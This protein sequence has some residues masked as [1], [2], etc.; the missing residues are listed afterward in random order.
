ML[1]FHVMYNILRIVA[2]NYLWLMLKKIYYILKNHPL[3]SVIM[4]KSSNFDA[5]RIFPFLQRSS[6]L[7]QSA[8]LIEL[9]SSETGAISGELKEKSVSS[10]GIRSRGED[11]WKG[12]ESNLRRAER[13]NPSNST[14]FLIPAHFRGYSEFIFPR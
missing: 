4:V 9:T 3:R 5:R 10:A 6:S 1:L 7:G 12:R 2:C 14:G 8:E 11:N 13:E